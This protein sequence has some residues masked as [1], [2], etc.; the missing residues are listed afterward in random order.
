[1][2]TGVWIDSAAAIAAAVAAFYA[3]RSAK[4]S[5]KQLSEQNLQNR[6]LNRPRLVPYNV[7][8]KTKVPF[9]HS[10][11]QTQP[12]DNLKLFVSPSM[13]RFS[14]PLLNVSS[15]LAINVSY[16]FKLEGGVDSVQPYSNSDNNIAISFP[17]SSIRQIQ[18]DSFSFKL[19]S[20][21]DLAFLRQNINVIVD[22]CTNYLSI[23]EPNQTEKVF[24]PHYFIILNN[25]FFDDQEK[26][27]RPTLI[28]SLKYRDQ[29]NNKIEDL[30][31]VRVS[32]K[33]LQI[34]RSSMDY[35]YIESWI[36]FEFIKTS[37]VITNE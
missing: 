32:K 15:Y 26:F 21:N 17:D 28:L 5:S 24:L 1:M 31:R 20:M 11:W 29:Y 23:V 22:S 37:Y 13:S 16:S 34:I 7:Q 36:E 8:L 27:P 35:D 2:S 10:D 9:I 33:Q 12:D 30:Y 19:T 3:G 4:I 6:K 25:I 18:P 14:I